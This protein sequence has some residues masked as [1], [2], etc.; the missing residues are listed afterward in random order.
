MFLVS[1]FTLLVA[2]CSLLRLPLISL[3]PCRHR[4]DAPPVSSA[5]LWCCGRRRLNQPPAFARPL[6]DA[7]ND[8]RACVWCQRW[9]YSWALTFSSQWL[10][11]ELYECILNSRLTVGRDW[12]PSL[13]VL[14]IRNPVEVSNSCSRY[15]DDHTPP[16][17]SHA[18]EKSMSLGRLHGE[19]LRA[20]VDV[21]FDIAIY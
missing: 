18:A 21:V 14:R 4:A 2:R 8:E 5:L 19:I 12:L 10:L 3:W 13:A 1:R 15:D 17:K 9:L 7:K 20:L 11:V 16:T 6:R